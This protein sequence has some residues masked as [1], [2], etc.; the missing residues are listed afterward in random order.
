MPSTFLPPS[1]TPCQNMTHDNHAT[2]QTQ[3]ETMFVMFIV[4]FL[5]IS[6]VTFCFCPRFCYF[7]LKKRL[8]ICQGENLAYYTISRVS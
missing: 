6:V 5:P 1:P 4:S 8:K 3:N 7:G 2:K